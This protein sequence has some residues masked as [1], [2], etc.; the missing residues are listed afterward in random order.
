MPD[1]NMKDLMNKAQEIQGQMQEAQKAITAIEVVGESGKGAH[2]VKVYLRGDH[3]TLRTE[4]SPVLLSEDEEI[5]EDLI[6]AAF[7]DAHKKIEEQTRAKM[8][9]F[10][11]VKLPE[12]FNTE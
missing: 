1:V 8:S 7:N 2:S 6:T 4:I 5:L 3:V 12:D 11:K 9:D 10:M